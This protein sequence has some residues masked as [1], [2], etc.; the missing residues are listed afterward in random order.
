MDNFGQLV[1]DGFKKVSEAAMDAVV[2]S[3]VAHQEQHLSSL[4]DMQKW[5][6]VKLIQRLTTYKYLHRHPCVVSV[7]ER[8][9]LN[10]FKGTTPEPQVEESKSLSGSAET[11]HHPELGGTAPCT[12]TD[13]LSRFASPVTAPPVG[14]LKVRVEEALLILLGNP[15]TFNQVAMHNYEWKVV[16]TCDKQRKETPP[17]YMTRGTHENSLSSSSLRPREARSATSFQSTTREPLHRISWGAD[18]ELDSVD[19]LWSDICI[20]IMWRRAPVDEKNVFTP[21]RPLPWSSD[22][23]V[24]LTPR[25]PSPTK[26]FDP[27]NVQMGSEEAEDPVVEIGIK[28]RLEVSTSSSIQE[29]AAVNYQ[30]QTSLLDFNPARRKAPTTTDWQLYGRAMVPLSSLLM[31][32]D[33]FTSRLFSPAFGN[34]VPW[35]DSSRQKTEN[36]SVSSTAPFSCDANS[37][38]TTC[39]AKDANECRPAKEESSCP[40][41]HTFWLHLFPHH[42]KELKYYRP[43]PGYPGLG[44]MNP[45]T[46]LG[47][48]QVDIRFVCFKSPR[49]ASILS[50]FHA[51][52]TRWVNAFSFEPQYLEAYGLRARH[53]ITTFPRWVPKFLHLFTNQTVQLRNAYDCWCILFFWVSVVT[54]CLFAR[55][56]WIPLCFLVTVLSISFSYRY[57]YHAVPPTRMSLLY[58]HNHQCSVSNFESSFQRGYRSGTFGPQDRDNR[59]QTEKLSVSEQTTSRRGT[60]KEQLIRDASSCVD[61]T[62]QAHLLKD[63]IAT[64]D[65]S[66]QTTQRHDITK[67]LPRL[68]TTRNQGPAYVYNDP[69]CEPQQ[70]RKAS[71]TKRVPPHKEDTEGIWLQS[72]YQDSNA[73]NDTRLNSQFFR[74]CY[75]GPGTRRLDEL[76]A[77]QDRELP[78]VS[79]PRSEKH[80]KKHEPQEAFGGFSVRNN[81]PHASSSNV[82]S[83]ELVDSNETP[84]RGKSSGVRSYKTKNA[85]FSSMSVV[86]SPFGPLGLTVYDPTSYWSRF[87]VFSDDAGDQDVQLLLEHG[88]EMLDAVQRLTGIF[89]CIVEK[90]KFAFNWEDPLLTAVSHIVLFIGCLQLTLTFYILSRFPYWVSRTVFLF[91]VFGFIALTDPWIQTHFWL[92][93]LG[94]DLPLLY[95]AFLS[96]ATLQRQRQRP[97]TM[98]R[99]PEPVD[100]S[101]KICSSYS[102]SVAPVPLSPRRV[103]VSPVSRER[104]YNDN[105]LGGLTRAHPQNS[106]DGHATQPK[107]SW[108][109]FRYRMTKIL[110]KQS[111]SPRT[112]THRLREDAEMPVGKTPR[113]KQ[114]V[115]SVASDVAIH[116]SQHGLR[117]TGNKHPAISVPLAD[118]VFQQ[119]TLS[120]LSVTGR[121]VALLRRRPHESGYLKNGFAFSNLLHFAYS[122]VW[123]VL[124]CFYRAG[125]CAVRY[126]PSPF[127]KV[128]RYLCLLVLHAVD[129]CLRFFW[130]WWLRLPDRREIEHRQI[131]AAQYIASLSTLLPSSFTA[132]EANPGSSRECDREDQLENQR[133]TWGPSG[134]Q[135]SNDKRCDSMNEV[136]QYIRQHFYNTCSQ[137][138]PMAG[139]MNMRLIKEVSKMPQNTSTEKKSGVDLSSSDNERVRSVSGSGIQ[140]SPTTN[141]K[142]VNATHFMT[143]YPSGLTQLN[144]RFSGADKV[145]HE[146]SNL[147]DSRSN[148]VNRTSCSDRRVRDLR[149]ENGSHSKPENFSQTTSVTSNEALYLGH[150]S[151]STRDMRQ[152]NKSSSCSVRSSSS[153]PSSSS[154]CKDVDNVSS[155]DTKQSTFT[156]LTTT[157]HSASPSL[158]GNQLKERRGRFFGLFSD[159]QPPAL[160]QRCQI[161][162][163]HN[164]SGSLSEVSQGV[165]LPSSSTTV[166]RNYEQMTPGSLFDNL[167]PDA[168]FSAADSEQPIAATSG[169]N[170]AHGENVM[171]DQVT[172]KNEVDNDGDG[173]L[174]DPMVVSLD[175]TVLLDKKD[176]SLIGDHRLTV[177]SQHFGSLGQLKTFFDALKSAV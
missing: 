112:R 173:C 56:T 108:T 120:V 117:R 152:P 146:K 49:W 151:R 11:L 139:L 58:Q 27:N 3:I 13:S 93:T 1:K 106:A 16:V 159:I 148:N 177:H 40:R 94:V 91:P 37:G 20:D 19:D 172:L 66:A 102:D 164:R 84:D 174:N 113:D 43:V 118:D 105:V 127:W 67:F 33:G 78:K 70:R 23:S 79:A 122:L 64:D 29:L 73:C 155:L 88:L 39:N 134:Q 125:C 46:T 34:M 124:H 140:M 45:Q 42:G 92:E 77:W 135:K 14:C 41:D 53:L 171:L 141:K 54:G 51:P 145:K 9:L 143:L 98:L 80:L 158:P 60:S 90:L 2:T 110:Q 26:Q 47:F 149:Q 62:R 5:S 12:K 38:E 50:I 57:G 74:S 128:G 59:M 7:H 82:S 44:M 166:P 61:N 131:A 6:I 104:L 154:L 163:S 165:D 144:Y 111:P 133:E 137:R 96:R 115:D 138:H 18:I 119:P 63:V 55:L 52:A 35:S 86:N 107:N 136:E 76:A 150:P 161:D 157:M 168:I 132:D 28:P 103:S 89:S 147:P 10:V 153:S 129:I 24:T 81:V 48:L 32:R 75:S 170:V 95:Y 130:H 156:T 175:K 72:R 100:N 31:S 15:L 97:P 167:R 69:H 30:A 8:S 121:V 85:P 4:Q 83:G 17:A 162:G 65:G 160:F 126:A 116:G 36:T 87:P 142:N 21:A 101:T 68:P 71:P 22:P 25:V 123:T 114:I 99:G 176:S 109:A 169:F